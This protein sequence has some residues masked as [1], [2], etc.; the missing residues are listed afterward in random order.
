MT[1][2]RMG[3]EA[4]RSFAAGREAIAEKREDLFERKLFFDE[5]RNTLFSGSLSQRQVDGMNAL[6]DAWERLSVI[7]PDLDLRWLAYILATDYHET[8]YT[9]QPIEEYGKGAGYDYG[10]P[11]PTTGECYYGRGLVQLTWASNYQNAGEKVHADLYWQPELALEMPISVRVI[12]R[13]MYEGWF[14]GKKLEDY[15]SGNEC[16]YVGARKIVNGT[17]RAE[18]IAGYAERFQSAL[19]VATSTV[20]SD[21][22]DTEEE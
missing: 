10:E 4:R 21:H 1:E 20:V 8:A 14:T 5:V 3:R 22:P 9:M 17:D 15:I 11:D 7:K 16:D 19:L 6:L 12:M 13:G 2:M 18:T